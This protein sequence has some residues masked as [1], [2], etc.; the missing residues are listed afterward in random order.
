MLIGIPKEKKNHEYRVSISPQGVN[1]LVHHGHQVIVEKDAGHGIGFDDLH[2]QDA[3]A[4]VVETAKEVYE[5]AEMIVKV[6]EPQLEE[7]R[8]IR[9]GQI[10]FGYLHLAADPDITDALIDTNCI[11]IAYE[12]VTDKYGRLPLLAPMSE[13]AGRFAVQAGA[14]CLERPRGGS[15][16]LLGGVPGVKKGKVVILGGGVV[17][18]NAAII[19]RGMGADVTILDKSLDRIRELEWQFGNSVN[20]L[21]S[22]VTSTTEALLSA[23]LVI[24]AV[25]IP[26]AAAPKIITKD[27]L[28]IMK[29]NAVI[30][31]VAIDQGGCAETSK[32]TTHEDPTFIEH[33]IIHYCVTNIPS[34]VARTSTQALENAT[35]PYILALADN[36]Y[37]ST[38]RNDKYFAMGLNIHRGRITHEAVANDLNHAYV[39]T[40][41]FLNG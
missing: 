31:D 19:A 40:S 6:K 30:V 5:R 36:G 26:G 10:I 7:C 25:L 29:R 21:Y 3:G 28:A 34:A 32:P 37:R 16:V 22:T 33:D 4:L 14:S 39:P 17:G 8:L 23:D 35:L 12:T 9:E 41:T 18:T 27:S 24:G 11:A 13:V 38:L 15:G 2:Y 1:E 20:I